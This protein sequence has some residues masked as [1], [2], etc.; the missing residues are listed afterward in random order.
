[1]SRLFLSH[2]SKDNVAAVAFKQWLG[3]IGWS[4]EDVYLDVDSIGAGERWKDALNKASAR[5]EAVVLLASPDALSSPE[6]L[7]EVRKAEDAGKE[8]IVV[9]LR[10]L[11]FDD[12][13]LDSYKDR[14]IVDLAAPP[15]DHVETVAYRG[16]RQ[17]VRFS[18]D[19]LARIKDFLA[20][21]GITPDRFAWPPPDK[22][23]AEPFP[24]LSAF[25]EEDAGIFFGRDA[26]IVRGLDKL[27]ILRRDG[28]P[29]LLVIQAA[30]GAG[31]SSYLRA[32]LWPR[33]VRDPDFA[34]LA[35]VRPAQGVLTGAQGLGGR[36][37]ARL[38][39]PAQPI[40]QGEIH[41][42]LMAPD[43]EKAAADFA[44]LMAAAAAQAY[45]ARR[46]GDRDA[47][48]PALIVAVDQAEELFG[49]DD[50]AESDRFLLLLARL[51]REPP[52]G[53]ELISLFTIR[54][55]GAAQLFQTI[56]DLGLEIPE[57]L[58][59]L[60]LPQTAYRD[61]I[62][63]PLDLLARRGQ[64][65]SLEPALADRLVADATGADALP[66]LAF[67]ISHLYREF[68]ATGALTIQQYDTVGGVAGSIDMALKRA[69]ARPADAPTIPVARQEQFALLRA[70]F[71]PWLARVD[72][73]TSAPTRRVARLDEFPPNA[74]AIAERLIEARLL[75]VDRRS[76]AEVAEVAHES[77]LRQWPP[78]TAWLEADA[79]DLKL[80]DAIE[81]ASG[82]WTRNA[83]QDGWLDHRAERLAAAER[84]AAREDFR[85][86][87][88]EEGI[89]YL[90]AC[91]ARETAE[92]EAK[93]AALKREQ[94]QVARTRKLQRRATWALAAVGAVV[95]IGLATVTV[96]QFALEEGRR[97]LNAQIEDNRRQNAMLDERLKAS[98]PPASAGET[99]VDLSSA[100]ANPRDAARDALARFGVEIRDVTPAGS[101]V[102]L[103]QHGGF[104]SDASIVP[105]VSGNF[106]AQRD[107]NNDPS[108][109]TLVFA[110]PLDAFVFMRPRLYLYSD[111]GI[112]FPAWTAT[113]LDSSGRVLS[114]HREALL[115][116]LPWKPN[117]P[118]GQMFS[119][120]A[121]QVYCLRRPGFDRIAAVRF[122]S[123]SQHF[124]AF[125]AM[126]IERMV[127]VR[128]D[129]G[130]ADCAA[131][132]RPNTVRPVQ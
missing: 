43:A 4:G 56:A 115:R 59:L 124:S 100:E 80:V 81:R 39:R 55:D 108:S 119:D 37:A 13:R 111:S 76:G 97:E 46:I 122:D 21:R 16:A 47:R 103:M 117:D 95:L 132:Y 51:L 121:A 92:R 96:Q 79:D 40:S 34:P 110:E 1:M 22:P 74:R 112:T 128:R 91:R 114:S 82:E 9:L 5:C 11:Q 105:T 88:G 36:F 18:N 45:E 44:R 28:R 130:G 57:T 89:A 69:L 19:A 32:G 101:S 42:R 50:K 83:R 113:A 31:K 94:A 68:A 66:L 52:A 35:V 131:A 8:I 38:S 70:T 12:H 98:T 24:G 49:A 25:T 27:R 17:E 53:V 99:D 14:Q 65:L 60:P 63:K 20:K 61:A 67:T 125:N 75:V 127:L 104:Y 106:L 58:P 15:Q 78:L 64:R 62:A 107:T 6:C 10:D 41:A 48:A 71:I 116:S 72:P 129:R 54:S 102:Q 26:D 87:L 30:S 3:A 73:Q 33:L 2:S 123:D 77:L 84:V 86:R 118:S 120:V 85:K 7:A 109:F 126:V 23:D 93:E 29:R 90:E